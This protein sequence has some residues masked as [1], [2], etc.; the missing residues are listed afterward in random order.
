MCVMAHL[1]PDPDITYLRFCGIIILY[2]N[3]STK[4]QSAFPRGRTQHVRRM[5]SSIASMIQSVLEFRFMRA[6]LH[7]RLNGR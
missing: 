5:R 2:T 6:I 3:D 4:S 7:S 1:K